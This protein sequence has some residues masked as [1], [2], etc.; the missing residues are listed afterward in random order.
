MD[1]KALSRR[2]F[3]TLIG[4]LSLAGL[5]AA[6]TTTK[7]SDQDAMTSKLEKLRAAK[8][9]K[10]KKI[11]I[12][13]NYYSP[14]ETEVDAGTIVIWENTGRS[15]HDVMSD[16]STMDH[17]SN[18]HDMSKMG[19]EDFSSDTLR[20]GNIHVALFDKPGK[21]FYHCHFHGGPQRGQWG[22]ITVNS[23]DRTP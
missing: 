21:Y 10:E 22:S 15:I 20:N 16:D 1:F 5:L 13:D 23:T 9:Y 14:K 11:E 7:A 3:I 18:S 6:C 19:D 17:D 8:K 2:D 4:G 12:G